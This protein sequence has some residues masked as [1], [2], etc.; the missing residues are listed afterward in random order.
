[1]DTEATPSREP[2]P[3]LTAAEAAVLVLAAFFLA[4]WGL[5]S[6]WKAS[7][8]ESVLVW[9][10]ARTVP[11]ALGFPPGNGAAATGQR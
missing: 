11:A 8:G 9:S 1:M 4:S 10:A 6:W 7:G 5:L 2:G 3:L